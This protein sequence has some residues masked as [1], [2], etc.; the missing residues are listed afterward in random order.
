MRYENFQV[1]VSQVLFEKRQKKMQKRNK[2]A[3]QAQ[4]PSPETQSNKEQMLEIST[5]TPS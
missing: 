3:T 1:H 4:P 2:Q 5:S